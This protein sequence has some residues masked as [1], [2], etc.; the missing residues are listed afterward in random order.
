MSDAR[1]R[2]VE[3]GRLVALALPLWAGCLPGALAAE[4]CVPEEPSGFRAS[5]RTA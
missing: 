1:P 5:G 4:D 2:F 3:T